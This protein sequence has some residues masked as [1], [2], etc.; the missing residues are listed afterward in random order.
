MNNPY[1]LSEKQF[2]HQV[3]HL[4][5]V[6]GWRVFHALP[7]QNSRGRWLTAQSGDVGFPDL[8]LAHPSK[9]VIFAE[10]KT[11]IGRVSVSQRIWLN[12]LEAAGAETYIWRPSDFDSIKTRLQKGQK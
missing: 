7:A 4:A 2:Q 10:L 12:T 11:Q 6:F 1:K 9:G 3:E 8:V 5:H